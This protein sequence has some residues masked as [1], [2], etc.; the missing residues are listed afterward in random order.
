[1][2]GTAIDQS[3]PDDDTSSTGSVSPLV[4][5]ILEERAGDDAQLRNLVA[6]LGWL[7]EYKLPL[8]QLSE[9]ARHRLTGNCR[10]PPELPEVF[11]PPW[12]DLLLTIGGRSVVAARNVKHAS[13]GHTRVVCLG[14][15]WAPLD[16][17]DLVVTTPQY[18]LPARPNVLENALP[19][20]H[21]PP[22]RGDPAE[23]AWQA[24]LD[25][26]PRPLVALLVG[27]SNGTYVLNE[28]AAATLAR[29]ASSFADSLG[30][31]LLIATSPRTN[32]ACARIL[33]TGMTAPGLL[34]DWSADRGASNPYA[35][36]LH[37]AAHAIVT[38]DSA[39]MLADACSTSAAVHLYDL[40]ESGMTRLIRHLPPRRNLGAMARWRDRLV[41]RGLWVPRKDLSRIHD[42]LIAS[43]R[44]ARLGE[45]PRRVE[46]VSDL[47]MT[48]HRIRK[49]MYSER[50]EQSQPMPAVASAS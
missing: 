21:A 4:W 28:R 41:A 45:A 15:P 35:L 7:C 22:L 37:H 36:F 31:S 17:F 26:L 10:R 24:R 14:R 38:S 50:A 11:T 2:R 12:P 46:N 43:G 27:A 39:S 30:G 29:R 5:A 34:Y 9:V 16:W 49:L 19:L 44:I 47:D 8:Y 13:G 23:Q 48:L 33:A 6:A 3:S 42:R 25:A 20:N 18:R 40:P 32:P 1:M